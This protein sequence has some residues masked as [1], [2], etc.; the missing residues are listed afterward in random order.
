MQDKLVL[1]QLG[2]APPGTASPGMMLQ[3]NTMFKE[4]RQS[5]VIDNVCSLIENAAGL[6][7]KVCVLV[8]M[9]CAGQQLLQWPALC[10]AC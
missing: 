1:Q 4:R 3:Y 9:W 7:V 10:V 6:M 5:L 2:P 8:L